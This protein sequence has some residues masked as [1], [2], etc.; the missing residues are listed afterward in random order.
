MS[1]FFHVIK[2]KIIQTVTKSRLNTFN[3]IYIMTTEEYNH[4]VELYSN[5]LYRFLLKNIKDRDTAKD[6][7]QEAFEK[8][9]LSLTMVPIEKAKAFLY[10]VAYR[11]MI[12]AIR[13]AKYGYLEEN[14][15][16]EAQQIEAP[17]REYTN[18]KEIL[19]Q[20]LE[21]LPELQKTMI[22]LRDYDDYSYQEIADITG[23]SITQVK[24]YLFRARKFL[25][26]YITQAE[27]V[28]VL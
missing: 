4:C 8:L 26:E 11:K 7:V 24:V 19:E 27:A 2:K 20:G 21:R 28:K 3:R 15:G 5:S 22:I 25:K 16:F 6:L 13:E 12:D 10:T 9:W 18:L 14:L 1:C 23:V 17:N